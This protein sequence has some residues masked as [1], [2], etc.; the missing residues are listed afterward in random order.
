MLFSPERDQIRQYYC[1]VW[2]KHGQ[3]VPLEPLECQIRDVILLHPEYQGLLE[4]QDRALG[5]DYLPE[6]GETNPFLHMGLHLAIRDQIA[7]DRP[8]GVRDI[9]R[10]IRL[11]TADAH[12]QEHR[13]MECLGEAIWHSQQQ[14]GTFDEAKY[15]NCLR[16]LLSG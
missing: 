5:K 12:A 4:Q 16:S 11:Q 9:S 8:N 10:R 13:L 1:D 14:G 2:R 6:F 7:T 15:L 3:G